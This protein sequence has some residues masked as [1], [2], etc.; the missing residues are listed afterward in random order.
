V[1]REEV[2]AQVRLHRAL[3]EVV[4]W[5]RAQQPPAR[6]AEVVRQDE[7]THDVIVPIGPLFVVYGTT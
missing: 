2:L 4:R 3:D 7:Y 5:G 1:T 6:I